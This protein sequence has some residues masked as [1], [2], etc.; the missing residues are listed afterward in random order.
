M[1][2]DPT[3][4]P[5]RVPATLPRHRPLT[6]RSSVIGYDRRL[7][8]A[9]LFFLS[10]LSPHLPVNTLESC[11]TKCAT[12]GE[13]LHDQAPGLPDPELQGRDHP[14]G[15]LPGTPV[16]L[17]TRL[18][19]GDAAAATRK[20][21][22]SLHYFPCPPRPCQRLLLSLWATALRCPRPCRFPVEPPSSAGRG[23]R[24]EHGPSDIGR[25]RVRKLERRSVCRTERINPR[26]NRSRETSPRRPSLDPVASAR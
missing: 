16:T 11:S 3:P 6:N 23:L 5:F 17:S 1:K 18:S 2:R 15:A 4:F 7:S 26:E 14:R 8:A 20:F 13:K 12:P 19:T 10:S 25:A 21:L 22:L 9:I 24:P